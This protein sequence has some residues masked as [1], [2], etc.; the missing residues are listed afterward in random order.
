MDFTILQAETL[1]RDKVRAFLKV[2]I[3]QT[4]GGRVHN[5]PTVI[6]NVSKN[7][8]MWAHAPE[9][10]LHIIASDQVVLPPCSTP[11]TDDKTLQVSNLEMPATLTT[12]K[13]K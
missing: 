6:D 3:P 13:L 2:V 12:W 9:D 5:I 7:L 8:D 11:S 1:D 10:V 4:I